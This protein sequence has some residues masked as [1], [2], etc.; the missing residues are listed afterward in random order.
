[1]ITNDEFYV[2]LAGHSAA[3]GHGKDFQQNRIITFHKVM[4]PVFDKIGVSC[5]RGTWAW[6]A[7]ERCSSPSL[8][9]TFTAKQISLNGIL[10]RI[11]AN[12]FVVVFVVVVFCP[13]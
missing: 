10:V 9:V 13:R 6:G 8:V 12:C 7:S 5:C 2:V 11:V 4:E 1:M 3:A